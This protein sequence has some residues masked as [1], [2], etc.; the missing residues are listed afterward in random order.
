[1]NV[2][3]QVRYTLRPYQREAVNHSVDFLSSN[4]NKNGIIVLPT[5]AGKSLVIAGIAEKLGAPVLIFQP[6]KE[7][8]E[9]NR[10]KLRAYGIETSVYSASFNSRQ[11]GN[12]TLA[13][14]GSVRKTP[15]IFEHFP[16]VL[17][18]ECHL[19][20]A[21]AGMYKEFLEALPSK[22]L[23]LTATPYRLASNSYG[24][25]LRFL[26]RTRPKIFHSV[27]YYAQIA[28]LLKSGYLADM[29][30]YDIEAV[31]IEQLTLNSTGA[32]FTDRSVRRHYQEIDFADKL[33]NTVKRLIK[34]GRKHI[35]AFTR[36]TAEADALVRSLDVPAAIVTAKTP[37]RERERILTQFKTGAIQII[38]NVGIL[39]IGFDFPALDTIVLARPTRSLA[40]YYQMIGRGIRPY[41]EKDG[42]VIDLCETVKQ[43]GRVR[44]L[45]MTAPA[46]NRNLWHIE[47]RGKQL[48]NVYY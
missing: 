17:V 23:G 45:W 2:G 22:I 24:S 42:W 10:E 21:K 31:K 29:K 46:R 47:S 40:L 27:V 1:M 19:V 36:F 34:A 44:D 13:T 15:E 41:P 39:T 38:A 18:D 9:Q 12:V 48:T 8:L 37:K 16:Y 35:L 4:G 20:N 14:I 3:D 26:T 43:F 6:R 11:I 25:I 33:L 5:G 28:D 7:I 32:D 30:Y